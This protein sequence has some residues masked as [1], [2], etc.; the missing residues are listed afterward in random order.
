MKIRWNIW[1]EFEAEI[2]QDHGDEGSVSHVDL[3]ETI[4]LGSGL[5]PRIVRQELLEMG[6]T[7]DTALSIESELKRMDKVIWEGMH[8]PA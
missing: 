1:L 4:K 5:T 7:N 8:E 2:S 3:D 6:V